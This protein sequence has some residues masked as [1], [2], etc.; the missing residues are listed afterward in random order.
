MTSNGSTHFK[1]ALL[2]G[3]IGALT[4]AILMQSGTIAGNVRITWSAVLLLLIVAPILEELAFREAVQSTFSAMLQ[5][6]EVSRYLPFTLANGVTSLTFAVFHLPS[7]ST[8]GAIATLAPSLILGLIRE[9]TGSVWKC[10]LLHAWFNACFLSAIWLL[11]Q[12]AS[13]Q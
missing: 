13:S 10:I 6:A 7:H 2:G 5:G 4:L 1:W 12:I 9:K 11:S 8:M 3:P